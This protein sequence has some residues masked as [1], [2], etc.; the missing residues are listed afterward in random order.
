MSQEEL[1]QKLADMLKQQQTM[2][3]VQREEGNKREEKMQGLLEAA[4]SNKP[5]DA[6]SQ[7][8]N[9]IPSNATPAP[10]L[11]HNASLREFTTWRQKFTDYVLLTGIDKA[12]NERQKAVLRSLLDDEWFRITKFALNIQMDD[13]GT[14]VD[15]IIEEMQKHLRSQR[16]VVLDRK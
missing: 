5:P 1:I 7:P 10:M 12:S 2:L 14:T 13:A 11:V 3:E 16:N 4:L 6:S 9:K 15:T 8:G